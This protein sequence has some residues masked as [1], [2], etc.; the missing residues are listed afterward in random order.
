[1]TLAAVAALGLA[2]LSAGAASPDRDALLAQRGG[3]RRA[4]GQA[5]ARTVGG[6]RAIVEGR[7]TAVDQE[8][9]HV[10]V[11]ADGASVDAEFP[12][13]TVASVK[14]GDQVLVT[15]ELIDTRVATVTGPVSAVDPATGAV[16]VTTASG[17]WTTKFSPG[18]VGAIKPGDQ[19]VLRLDLTDMGPPIEPPAMLPGPTTPPPGGKR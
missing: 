2:A 5:G 17:P 9:G 13:A 19:V 7:V 6:L 15:V 18:A 16:T 12:R 3:G 4:P 10:T 14:P 11:S 1:M 8:T